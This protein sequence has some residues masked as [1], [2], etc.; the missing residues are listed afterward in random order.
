MK[1][2]VVGAGLSGLTAAR[3]LKDDWKNILMSKYLRRPGVLEALALIMNAGNIFL[4]R[5]YSILIMILPGTLFP[6][7]GKY[8]H[9]NIA[10]W[11]MSISLALFLYHII[12]RQKK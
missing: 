3:I 10:S 9:I 6:V 1:A 5:I 8:G 7:S 4:A 11:L 12:R 2:V